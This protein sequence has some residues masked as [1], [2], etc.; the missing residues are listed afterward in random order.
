[1][2]LQ[3]SGSDPILCAHLLRRVDEKLIDLLRS[4]APDEWN[5]QTI[6]P[7]WKVRDVAAHLLDT[8]LRKLSVVRD[9]CYAE[10]VSI[11][12]PQDVI[13]LVNRLN[14]EG[15]TVYRRLS[16]PVLIDMMAM[17]CEQSACFHESLD[18]FAPATFAVSWAG[19]E[20]SL[21]WF[22]TARELTERWHHQQQIRF[23]THRPGIMTPDLYHP[24][25]DCFVRGMPYVYRDID[26]PEGTILQLEISGDCGGRWV[27]SRGASGWNFMRQPAADFASRVTIPQTLA[28]RL[29]TKGID[30]DSARAQIEVEG[31]RELGERILDLTAIVG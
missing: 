26:V 15:V 6:S 16:P 9:S 11:Q 21:N 29:F 25:L 20:I 4:L 18:P 12:S 8:V 30:R 17:A 7:L 1:M 13:A 27:L 31:N 2:S 28:W 5:I 23:A 3:S 22:D 19:E 24:V 14:L 10:A